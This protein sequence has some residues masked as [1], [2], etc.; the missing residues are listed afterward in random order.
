VAGGKPGYVD[1]AATEALFKSPGGITVDPAGNLFVA[2]T[3]N[4]RIRKIG[5]DGTVTTVAGAGTA[6]FNDGPA[7]S[8]LFSQPCGLAPDGQGGLYVGDSGN[9]RIRHLSASE[10]VKTVAG[11]GTKGGTDGATTSASFYA[12][13]GIVW[14]PGALVVADQLK[15]RQITGVATNCD[16]GKACTMDKCDGPTGEC[17]HTATPAGSACEDGNACTQQDACDLAGSCSGV[18]KTCDDGSPCTVDTCNP[19]LGECAHDPVPVACDDGNPCTQTD[20]CAAGKCVTG[21]H[22]VTTVAGSEQAGTIDGVGASARL[23]TPH[24]LA[25][26]PNGDVYFSGGDHRIRKLSA[27]GV[28][29]TVAGK[30]TYGNTNG[31]ALQAAFNVP[32][33]L[34]FDAGGNLFIADEG[35]HCIRLLTEAGMVSTIAGACKGGT[36]FKD[37]A[38]ASALFNTITGLAVDSEER[39]FVLDAN[40]YRIRMVA[41]GV[42]STFAGAD[43]QKLLDGKGANARLFSAWGLAVDSQD[44]LWFSDWGHIRRADPDGTVTTIAGGDKEFVDGPLEAARFTFVL[45]VAIGPDASLIVVD[46]QRLRIMSKA[47]TVTTWAGN[48]STAY[49]PGPGL[50]TGL[51]QQ[52]ISA[53][54]WKNGL[55]L[56]AA[57]NL[58]LQASALAVACD[59]GVDCTQ[60]GCNADTL[61]CTHVPEPVGTAC[62]D[63]SECTLGET[64]SG[65]KCTGGQPNAC[66]DADPCTLDACG[67]WGCTHLSSDDAGCCKS[68]VL[69]IMFDDGTLEGFT[70]TP[71][72]PFGV[73]WKLASNLSHSAPGALYYGNGINYQTGDQPN[74]GTAT[75]PAFWVPDA[76]TAL[77]FWVWPDIEG[78]TLE[79]DLLFVEVGSDAD[80]SVVWKKDAV[81]QWKGWSKQTVELAAWAGRKVQVRFRFDSV[82]TNYNLTTGVHVDDVRVVRA[83]P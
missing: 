58:L 45:G 77:E 54:P 70:T 65:A 24:G 11:S 35:N 2:D 81:A 1:G 63:G 19:Y 12:P 62:D 60:D 83:C 71:Q 41:D 33:R 10:N 67:K 48:G 78:P 7:S 27:D 9:L 72:G 4:Q 44:R 56:I 29:T 28:I 21:Q 74:S 66:N 16:D 37:G 15:V 25:V 51:P 6:G 22:V 8:A 40:N 34:A 64:C 73:G 59:D 46:D 36:G 76:G 31:P 61:G 30:A 80:W 39:L 18:E 14:V 42:V 17:S 38:A 3:G 53:V 32:T 13:N 75:S 55:I 26:A 5:I 68:E 50:L 57:G 82:D 43:E 69:S 79:Y 49:M 52:A 23:T 47:G 20:W